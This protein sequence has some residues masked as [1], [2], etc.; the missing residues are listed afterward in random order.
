MH[1]KWCKIIAPGAFAWYVAG[2]LNKGR[3]E[4]G[5]GHGAAFPYAEELMA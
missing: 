3:S 1:A 5:N 4:D 2:V